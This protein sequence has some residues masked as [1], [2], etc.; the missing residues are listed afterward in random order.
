MWKH[1]LYCATHTTMLVVL[2]APHTLRSSMLLSDLRS[3]VD[4]LTALDGARRFAPE[5]DIMRH[6]WCKVRYSI[7]QYFC[8][9]V[10]RLRGGVV[11][12]P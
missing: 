8:C 10:F 11:Y 3:F 6:P 1:G 7:F 9:I 4:G 5:A 12:L 2:T